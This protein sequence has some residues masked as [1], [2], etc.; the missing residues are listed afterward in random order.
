MIPLAAPAPSPEAIASARD[1]L[2]PGAFGSGARV[3]T[4]EA[5]FADLV[6]R[7]HAVAL[8]N[9]TAAVHVAC[10]AHGIRPGQ[11]VLVAP[12]ARFAVPSA[13]ALCGARPAFVDLD[14][15]LY[16]IDPAK[17]KAAVTRRAAAILPTHLF[18]EAAEMEALVGIARERA[19][20]VIEDAAE[21]RGTE[22]HGRKAGRLGDSACF[23]F[24]GPTALQGGALATD[25]DGV[26][27]R[28]RLL[29]DHGRAD[30][31]EHRILGDDYRMTEVAAAAC[32]AELTGTDA[33]VRRRR[34]NARALT[35][36]L[37]GIEGL[38]PPAE[39]NW[40][41]HAY[42]RYVVRAEPKFPL[43]RDEIVLAL[44]EDGVESAA[45]FAAPLYR[46]KALRDLR[47]RAR[48]AVAEQVVGRL[49]ELPVHPGL[50]PADVDRIVD[51]LDRLGKPA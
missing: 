8:A 3:A 39:G 21:A 27:E 35:N 25:D 10:M 23:A 11:D 46:Q 47:V 13:V 40:T 30:G 9:G 42:T 16:T 31:G 48:C 33:A 50:S 17:A 49:F 18:G 12:L 26:A 4:L 7:R 22:Y 29:R 20:A 5:A 19:L 34:E 44:A 1:A 45:P 43:S 36:A 38:V 2:G 28:A 24:G 37:A 14:R 41:V 32:L 15:A 6:G 51:A